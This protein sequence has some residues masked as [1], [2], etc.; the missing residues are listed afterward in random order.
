MRMRSGVSGSPGLQPQ[1][2][3]S[4]TPCCANATSPL[5][6]SAPRYGFR[7]ALDLD[8]Q[9]R[10]RRALE[11][12]ALEE[13]RA[14]DPRPACARRKRG[15]P[16]CGS[17]RCAAAR[18]VAREIELGDGR[19]KL[20]FGHSSLSGWLMVMPKDS[21]VVLCG[22]VLRGHGF[23]LRR[24]GRNFRHHGVGRLVEPQSFERRLPEQ[25]AS[26]VAFS[27]SISATSFGSTQFTSSSRGGAFENGGVASKA[28]S[29]AKQIR[30]DLA[31]ITRSHRLATSRFP[32]P[33]ECAHQK[34]AEFVR[35]SAPGA[36]HHLLTA[37]AFRFRPAVTAAEKYGVAS[38]ALR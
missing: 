14:A 20:R 22:L 4:V 33:D 15:G 37:A 3:S 9:H 27:N 35:R 18:H 31:A 6:V 32:F 38:D 28:A 26:D 7:F 24:I 13:L 23:L 29:A 11:F 8:G 16:S 25:A 2:C 30:A 5:A 34:R 1:G 17:V 12:V 21:V 36:D 19:P 10:H